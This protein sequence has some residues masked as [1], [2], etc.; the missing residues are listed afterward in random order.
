MKFRA[1]TSQHAQGQGFHEL[2]S[3][4]IANYV[5]VRS[6][7]QR[8]QEADANRRNIEFRGNTFDFEADE[9]IGE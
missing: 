7:P 5:F 8:S 4:C 6:F 3:P 9:V 1:G 2:Q